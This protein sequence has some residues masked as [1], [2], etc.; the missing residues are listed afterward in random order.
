VKQFPHRDIAKYGWLDRNAKRDE[1]VRAYLAYFGVNTPDEWSERY[2]RSMKE[3]AFR[4]SPRLPPNSA[5]FPRGC[6]GVKLK[7]RQ[8]PVLLGIPSVLKKV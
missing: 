3:T 5:L 8:R 2:E 4:T 7:R 1:L 6:D